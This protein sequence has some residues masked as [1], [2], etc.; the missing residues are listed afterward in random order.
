MG[1][2]IIPN[3]HEQYFPFTLAHY[4]SYFVNKFTLL[5][6]SSLFFI[7]L[8]KSWN[9]LQKDVVSTPVVLKQVLVVDE[10]AGAAGVVVEHQLTVVLVQKI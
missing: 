5:N 3:S 6:R 10:A 9:L 1:T 4:R 7:W 8:Q 2:N